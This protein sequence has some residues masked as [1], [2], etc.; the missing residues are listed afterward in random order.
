MLNTCLKKS[1]QKVKLAHDRGCVYPDSAQNTHSSHLSVICLPKYTMSNTI[2]TNSGDTPS[3][4][5]FSP[6]F[7]NCLTKKNEC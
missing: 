3:P 4:G 2:D 6:H 7:R 5:Y 1:V